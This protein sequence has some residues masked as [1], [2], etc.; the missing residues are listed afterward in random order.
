MKG[1]TKGRPA[2]MG[3]SKGQIKKSGRAGTMVNLPAKAYEKVS[4]T[5]AAEKANVRFGQRG[6][7]SRKK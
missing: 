6:V 7:T 1:G 5:P 3:M 2:A 4:N